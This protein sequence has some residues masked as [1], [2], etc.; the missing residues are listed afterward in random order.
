MPTPD[1][2]EGGVTSQATLGAGESGAA[3][4]MS[5]A[6]GSY[7]N[8]GT[9]RDREPPPSYN[10]DEPELTFRT[11]E[12]NVR[13]WEYE[14]DIPIAKRGV[15]LLRALSGAARL[16]V[17]EMAF[18][19]IA[20]DSGVRNI[21]RRLQEHFLPHLE[22]SLPRAFEAAVYGPPRPAKEGFNEYLAK[23]DKAFIR[24]KKEG[25][26]L[27][28]DAQGYIIYRQA[29]LSE[30]Q[31]QRFLVWADGKYDRP[32][33]I[34]ALR[35]LDKVVKEKNK[36]SFVT[37]E[38]QEPSVFYQQEIYDLVANEDDENVVYLQEGDLDEVIDEEDM[39]AALAS[40]QE[41]RRAVREQDKGRGY[42]K[43]GFGKGFGKGKGKG[44]WQRVHREQLKLRTRCWRCQQLGHISRECR[45]D[46]KPSSTHASSTAGSSV[47]TSKT[48][49]LVV[50]DS[51]DSA[52]ESKAFWLRQFVK[53]RE[54]AKTL[55][56]ESDGVYKA[57]SATPFCEI[58]THAEH[59]VVDTAA[60]GGLIGSKALDRLQEH[61]NLRGLQCKWI[62]KKSMAK[63]VG[64][65][66]TVLGVVM[67]PI[68]VG[69]VNGVL[70]ATVV[71]GDVPLLLPIR[72][73]RGLKSVID[74]DTMS[75]SMKRY[76]VTVEM[77][78]L[79]S[80]HVTVDVM[81]FENDV[82]KMPMEIPECS[83]SDFQ[84]PQQHGSGHLNL[85]NS[86]A[87]VAQSA[88]TSNSKPEKIGTFQQ[89]SYGDAAG[90]CEEARECTATCG[91][92]A[93]QSDRRGGAPY[94]KGIEELEG[95]HGQGGNSTHLLKLP[96]SGRRVVSTI[97]TIFAAIG[98]VGHQGDSAGRLCR[99]HPWSPTFGTFEV[100]R[101]TQGVY[102]QLC[103]SE[104]GTSR[105]WKC[106]EVVH[107]MQGVQCQVGE[108][109]PI[110]TAQEGHENHEEHRGSLG[111]KEGT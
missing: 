15:K 90:A 74:L 68:G 21:M 80:G 109:I 16:A 31:E 44:K 110:C 59:G 30:S 75:L 72:M 8:G 35:K 42:Y 45:N 55:E 19:E 93:H 14:T 47:S 33:V 88:N 23:M 46:P 107:H 67:L 39:M 9:Y 79:P 95:Y 5:T 18:E 48:G 104:E 34:K 40:Y 50:S 24:L 91:A 13:L 92:A 6:V 102:Q 77:H 70:E 27:S 97:A 12:K 61:L 58:V 63:G 53:E 2:P 56:P 78:E 85:C 25:V 86:V 98:G 37:E 4:V 106:K 111:S 54:Q 10:G 100:K 108:S 103:A 20:D 96:T 52:K 87:M 26:E 64:G 84:L 17:D 81:Q 43:G 38:E 76:G 69:G 71:E 41:I 65:Q 101:S 94:Q 1:A 82:F 57:A 83:S 73:L 49:F 60:E 99:D 66:A 32:S 11:F 7:E 3:A 36:T 22:V 62:P 89:A 29:A 28:D 105:R 51:P